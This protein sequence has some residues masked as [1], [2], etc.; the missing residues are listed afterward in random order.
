MSLGSDYDYGASADTGYEN[1]LSRGYIIDGWVDIEPGGNPSRRYRRPTTRRGLVVTGDDGIAIMMQI[2]EL[3]S[4]Y[5]YYAG[6]TINFTVSIDDEVFY[7]RGKLPTEND[8][9]TT[10]A[11][12]AESSNTTSSG[13]SVVL[14][15]QNRYRSHQTMPSYVAVAIELQKAE[16]FYCTVNYASLTFSALNGPTPYIPNDHITEYLRCCRYY[17]TPDYGSTCSHILGIVVA[18]DNGGNYDSY[19]AEGYIDVPVPMSISTPALIMDPGM[20]IVSGIDHY[21]DI[22]NDMTVNTI[23]V[24]ESSVLMTTTTRL[25]VS[26]TFKISNPLTSGRTYLL[27]PLPGVRHAIIVDARI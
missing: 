16:G 4:H 3:T 13:V 22:Y 1:T 11:V 15:I 12:I 6:Q 25:N 24:S 23:S 14:S 2:V 5:Q 10:Y 9:T 19:S 21:T 26:L 7:T 18:V 8:A 20:L 27:R 17:W